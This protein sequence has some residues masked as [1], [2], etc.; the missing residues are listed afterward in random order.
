MTKEQYLECVSLGDV[1]TILYEYYKEQF[2]EK[3]HKKL[4][5]VMEFMTLMDFTG[6]LQIALD[7]A[8]K[9]YEIQYNIIRV[10]DENRKLIKII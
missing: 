2:V 4:L 5:P 8:I 6:Y 10:F 9:F 1:N 3:R 7:Q